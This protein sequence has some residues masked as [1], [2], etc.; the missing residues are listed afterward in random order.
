MNEDRGP[1]VT[2][3]SGARFYLADPQPEDYNISDIAAGLSKDCR[4]GGQLAADF[5]DDI[6]S[7][8]QHSVYVDM[9]V[10]RMGHPEARP[11]AI[12]HDAPEGIYGDMTSP[13]KSISPDYQRREALAEEALIARYSIPMSDEIR[14]VV[15]RADKM[16]SIME[17]EVLTT[18]KTDL[19]SKEFIPDITLLELD[20]DFHCWRP[21][22]ARQEFLQAVHNQLGRAVY[23]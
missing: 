10:E 11:W 9:V 20:P 15:H 17:A 4:Y 5:D 23:D 13:Q 19:W 1:W 8:A 3:R 12:M 22:K 7:V 21:L 14:Q 6:Y 2:T 18:T 16:V